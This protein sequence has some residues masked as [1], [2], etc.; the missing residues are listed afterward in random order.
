MTEKEKRARR[1]AKKFK[2]QLNQTTLILHGMDEEQAIDYLNHKD[3][4]IANHCFYTVFG[5]NIPAKYR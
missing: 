5:H 1:Q 3:S 4:I 2:E